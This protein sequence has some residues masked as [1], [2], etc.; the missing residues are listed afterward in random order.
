MDPPFISEEVLSAYGKVYGE[1]A[2]S[3]GSILLFTTTPE[4]Q[5]VLERSLGIRVNTATFLPCIPNLV[6]QYRIFVNYEIDS[7]SP[8]WITNGEVESPE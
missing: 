8:L 6:Y 7:T 1:L 2:K 5:Q 4:N 3:A